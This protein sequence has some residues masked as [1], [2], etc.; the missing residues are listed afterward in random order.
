MCAEEASSYGVI[1][2]PT[3]CAGP[4]HCWHAHTLNELRRN[5]FKAD[6]SLAYLPVQ[7]SSIAN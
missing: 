5:P 7:C 3:E 2:L 1:N 4:N 6:G